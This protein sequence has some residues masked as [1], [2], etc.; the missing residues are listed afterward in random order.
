MANKEVIVRL[1]ADISGLKRSMSDAQK[2]VSGGTKGIGSMFKG[3]TSTIGKVVS[4]VGKIA[5]TVGVFKLVDS[6]IGM[7]TGSVGDAVNR[8]DTLRNAGKVFM[9]MGFGAEDA[10]RMMKNLNESITGL[11][12]PLDGAVRSVQ[13]LSSATQDL[14]R[15]EQIFSAMNNGILGFGGSAQDVD[16]AVNMLSRSIGR[17]TMNGQEWNSIYDKAPALLDAL[18]GSMGYTMDEL[19]TGLS[20]GTISM[21]DFEDGMI[22]LNKNGT[23]SMASL[24]KMAKDMTGGISTSIANMRTAV[25]RGMGNVIESFDEAMANQGLPT[26]AEMATIVGQKM[27]QGLTIA[28]DAIGKIIPVLLGLYETV[29]DSTAWQTFRDAIGEI[30]DIGT[31]LITGFFQSDTWGTIKET[32]K[33]LAQAVLDIDFKKLTG[34]VVAFLDTWSPLIAGIV[35]AIAVFKVINGLIALKTA[36]VGGLAIAG[37][38]LAGVIAFLTSPIG[39]IV[40]AIGALIAIGVYLWKN[41]EEIS[42]KASEI[43]GGC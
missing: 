31:E 12:T 23:D 11:P 19:R 2:T 7:I 42:A 30:I 6:A 3:V 21:T 18:A 9:N 33:D 5:G 32:L 35:G 17:G 13:T 24:E 36:L 27:N 41:W 16:G 37:K 1:G 15:A 14:D 29:R 22:D 40:V 39:I 20:E 38:I 43:W 34:D 10:D 26:L 28:G 4:S 8:V 25:V